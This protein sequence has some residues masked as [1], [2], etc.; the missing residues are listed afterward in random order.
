MTTTPRKRKRPD[1]KPKFQVGDRVKEVGKFQ[2]NISNP[3]N[4]TEH[5]K[6]CLELQ[7]RTRKGTVTKV[8]IKPDRR[9]NRI[10]FMEVLWDGFT[11]PSE[12]AQLRLA[13]LDSHTE[14]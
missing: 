5:V 9:G 14:G 7:A 10:L 2:H 8:L 13:P 6:R 11:T 3:F 1:P 4:Q 12:H